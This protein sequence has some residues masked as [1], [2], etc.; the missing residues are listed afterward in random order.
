MKSNDHAA[1]MR[2]IE[3]GILVEFQTLDVK[4]HPG[5][6][7]GEFSVEVELRLAAN[8]DEAEE[9]VEWG[10]F[11]FI[12]VLAVLSFRDARPRGM[13]VDEYREEDEFS[14]S[15]FFDCL[16]FVR[17]QLH[18]RADY[19]RGRRLKTDID[20]RAD[21]TATIT[22]RG[23]GKTV[24]RWLDQLKGKKLVSVVESEEQA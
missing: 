7:E 11:G 10:A 16:R 22:T 24:M 15:D 9:V 13:S 3:T 17:G 23:R 19:L 12:F 18:F 2:L 6:D 5:P 4:V 14:V 1:G 20:I 21:G 8:E